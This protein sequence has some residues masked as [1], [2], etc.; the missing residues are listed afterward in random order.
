MSIKRNPKTEKWSWDFFLEVDGQPRTGAR[1][2]RWW[3]R[4]APAATPVK[5]AVVAAVNDPRRSVALVVPYDGPS[6]RRTVLDDVMPW[7]GP[8]PTF[9]VQ[10]KNPWISS[11]FA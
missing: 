11:G 6:R 10:Q 5:V 1:R 3:R 4:D 2:R 7:R 8:S 9:H